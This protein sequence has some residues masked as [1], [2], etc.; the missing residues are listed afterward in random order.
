MEVQLQGLRQSRLVDVARMLEVWVKAAYRLPSKPQVAL[1]T[2]PCQSL[3][4][5]ITALQDESAMPGGTTEFPSC[6]SKLLGLLDK[7]PF[8]QEILARDVLGDGPGLDWE[9][10][11][12]PGQEPD[13]LSTEEKSGFTQ[14]VQE[15]LERL[16]ST[17]VQ[18]A[19]RMLLA[20]GSIWLMIGSRLSDSDMRLF[21]RDLQEYILKRKEGGHKCQTFTS[22]HLRHDE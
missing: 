1:R 4:C 15:L 20:R 14:K 17:N 22:P 6:V 18:P 2:V 10:V 13:A 16:A 5:I 7:T 9:Y 19:S 21:E 12:I 3:E 11:L 8:R